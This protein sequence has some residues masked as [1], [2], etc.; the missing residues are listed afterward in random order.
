MVSNFLSYFKT[1]K[2]KINQ[3]IKGKNKINKNNV[4]YVM[5]TEEKKRGN[6]TRPTLI[7]EGLSMKLSL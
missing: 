3:H 7:P 4:K 2:I 6:L 1:K 5:P